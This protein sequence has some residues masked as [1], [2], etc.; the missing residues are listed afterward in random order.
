[1]PKLGMEQIRRRQAIEAVLKCVAEEGIDKVT[2]DKTA[3]AAGVSKG[4]IAYYFKS[5]EKL[6][7]QS[8]QAFLKDYLD[9]PFE[10]KPEE[11][12]SS[13]EV[14]LVIGKSVL[15]LFPDKGEL[16]QDE[17][18]RII[19]QIYSKLT[20]SE[21]YREMIREIYNQYLEMLI[22]L[23]NHGIDNKEFTVENIHSKAMQ[24]LALMEG[25]IIYSIMGFQ[26]TNEDH[27][28]SYKDFVDNL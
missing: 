27:F 15:G 9:I 11:T 10:Y 5:K 19:L 26:G 4:V 7:F 8:L 2:L 18:K 20:I 28:K 25:L 12:F 16:T 3:K 23:L 1:M 24:L 14:L 22:L 21:K 6:I 17:K 13:K